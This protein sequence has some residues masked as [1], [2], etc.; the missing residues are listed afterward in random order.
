MNEKRHFFCTLSAAWTLCNCVKWHFSKRKKKDNKTKWNHKI[1]LHKIRRDTERETLDAVL[2]RDSHQFVV[3]QSIISSLQFVCQFH[4]AYL[5]HEMSPT[6]ENTMASDEMRVIRCSY[7]RRCRHICVAQ[8]KS[9]SCTNC[10]MHARKRCTSQC[11]RQTKD[12]IDEVKFF[13]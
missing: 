5:W 12:T 9:K 8:G 7:C 13:E 11:F 10:A 4:Y 1:D 2:R 3:R 6:H